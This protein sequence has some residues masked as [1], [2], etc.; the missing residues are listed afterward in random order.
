MV[1][2]N[3]AMVIGP[4]LQSSMNTSTEMILEFLNGEVL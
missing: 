2:V 1:T 4:I 3:P